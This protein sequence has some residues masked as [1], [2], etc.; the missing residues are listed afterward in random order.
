MLPCLT[1]SKHWLFLKI[2]S[3]DFICCESQLVASPRRCSC[4][5]G[6]RLEFRQI[7][8]TFSSAFSR[9]TWL[10]KIC[11]VSEQHQSVICINLHETNVTHTPCCFIDRKPK[12]SNSTQTFFCLPLLVLIRP[13]SSADSTAGKQFSPDFSH[14]PSQ[15]YSRYILSDSV[16][17]E[18]LENLADSESLP[19]NSVRQK[20]LVSLNST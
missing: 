18:S 1:K 14:F 19:I 11:W 12:W 10:L 9:Q 15:K 13:R 6:I 20:V 16:F 8:N 17:R 2:I 3:S 4:I 7:K 5:R